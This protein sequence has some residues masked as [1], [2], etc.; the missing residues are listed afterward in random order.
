MI[1]IPAVAAYIK[2]FAS[3]LT[4]PGISTSNKPLLITKSEDGTI[5]E[6]EPPAGLQ[7]Q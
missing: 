2:Q 7:S 1:E 6:P 3:S 5:L 4:V